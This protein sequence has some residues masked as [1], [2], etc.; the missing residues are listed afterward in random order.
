MQYIEEMVPGTGRVS[1]IIDNTIMN[2]NYRI[3]FLLI[4]MLSLHSTGW[5]RP[6]LINVCNTGD[7]RIMKFLMSKFEHIDIRTVFT[8]S[9]F[10][11]AVRSN[12]V[13]LV[14]YF[15]HQEYYPNSED[16]NIIS[17]AVDDNRLKIA[18]ML[19]LYGAN[20]DSQN[21]SPLTIAVFKGYVKM[22]KLLLKHGTNKNILVHD[23]LFGNNSYISANRILFD[24]IHGVLRTRSLLSLAVHRGNNNITQLLFNY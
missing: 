22:V 9:L 17:Y 24:D 13:Q 5:I 23:N 15:L 6:Q 3:L 21:G 2:S 10:I 4:K 12:H 8:P 7:L 20:V 18:N 11:Q 19:I 16:D 14:K 1:T